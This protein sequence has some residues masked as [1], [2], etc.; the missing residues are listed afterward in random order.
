ML[1]RSEFHSMRSEDR[2]K[3]FRLCFPKDKYDED[4]ELPENVVNAYW[5]FRG[6]LLSLDPNAGLSDEAL[7]TVFML[8]GSK[9]HVP[10]EANLLD[11][12]M[13]GRLKSGGDVAYAWHGKTRTGRYAGLKGTSEVEV[14]D[15]E[16]GETRVVKIENAKYT[17]A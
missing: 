9:T 16:T 4:R 2:S 14:I 8:S 13:D 17:A 3:L 6:N 12:V 1:T 7:V 11:A 10:E 15:G 5:D